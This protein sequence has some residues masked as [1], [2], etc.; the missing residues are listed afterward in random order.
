MAKEIRNILINHIHDR[1][2]KR[3]ASEYLSGRLIDIGCGTKPYKDMLAS[4]V[5]EHIGIDHQD[6]LHDKSNIDRFGTAYDI[7]AKDGEF[8]CALC[9]AV[10]EHLE[11]PEQALCECHRVLKRGGS[12][13]FCAIYM[14][15]ARGGA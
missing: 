5:T 13:L 12:H 4:Y 11:E 14:A 2:L 10:L 1:E 15:S 8:D 3:Y 9:T 7:S 6:T